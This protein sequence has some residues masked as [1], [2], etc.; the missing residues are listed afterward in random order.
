MGQ[1]C[2][3]NN[4]KR[5]ERARQ[6]QRDLE[7]ME[8]TLDEVL[9]TT[10]SPLSPTL[11]PRDMQ[12]G[13]QARRPPPPPP[14]DQRP[15]LPPPPLTGTPLTGLPIG[16]LPLPP[17]PTNLPPPLPPR[18]DIGGL[19]PPPTNL[20]PPLP[21]RDEIGDLP[22]PP[23][24]R[25]DEAPDR[26]KMTDMF[27]PWQ[28][29]RQ[30]HV[31][32]QY[33]DMVFEK[34]LGNSVENTKP[35]G[36]TYIKGKVPTVKDDPSSRGQSLEDFSEEDKAV[37]DIASKVIT[38]IRSKLPRGPF[39]NYGGLPD[40]VLLKQCVPG[41]NPPVHAPNWWNT[42]VEITAGKAAALLKPR[43]PDVNEYKLQMACLARATTE[44]GGGVCSK[45]AMVT[46]GELT[47]AMPEGSEIV[48]VVSSADHEFVI[49]RAPGSRW[50]VVDPWTQETSVIP[51]V[52]CYFT[53]D[54]INSFIAINVKEPAP[55]PFGIDV[56]TGVNWKQLMRAAMN[57][58][59]RGTPRQLGHAFGQQHNVDEPDEFDPDL[60]PLGKDSWG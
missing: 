19:P 39:N 3:R 46:S 49:A 51:F 34:D 16:D 13:Q 24:P 20:P 4:R 45:M 36:V 1:C 43:L 17:P 12:T 53:P 41:T 9:G 40:E 50:F 28:I 22:P 31:S 10:E 5:G 26:P 37:V 60:K 6:R 33:G 11:P 30:A 2:G 32:D 54:S 21:P 29:E 23:P 38:G 57:E 55:V 15:N 59:P 48:Q 44:V 42:V 27:K 7:A 35:G 18:D 58:V 8:G 52:D 47:K 56:E 25:D 14:R